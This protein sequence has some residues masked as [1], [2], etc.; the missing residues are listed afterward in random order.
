MEAWKRFE[1]LPPKRRFMI[2]TALFTTLAEGLLCGRSFQPQPTNSEADLF[3]VCLP[4]PG[5]IATVD[6]SD[7]RIIVTHVG[8][9]MVVEHQHELAYPFPSIIDKVDSTAQIVD[10]ALRPVTDTANVLI[11]KIVGR[12]P[13]SSMPVMGLTLDLLQIFNHDLFSQIPGERIH[14]DIVGNCISG[15]GINLEEGPEVTPGV[16]LSIKER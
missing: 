9:G 4:D 3:K 2:L 11:H 16:D 15:S 10:S 13:T 5:D 14:Y 8:E 6:S 1:D 12:R 7:D